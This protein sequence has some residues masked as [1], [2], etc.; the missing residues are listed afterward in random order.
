MGCYP[1][2]KDISTCFVEGY[3][4]CGIVITDVARRVYDIFEY[5]VCIVGNAS[6]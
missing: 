3:Y 2:V 4:A 5:Y 1:P 6:R